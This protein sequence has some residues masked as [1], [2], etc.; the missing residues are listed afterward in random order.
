MEAG[1]KIIPLSEAQEPFFLGI[2]VGGMSTKIGLV[3]NFGKVIHLGSCE[4]KESG[5]ISVKTEMSPQSATQAMSKAVY[6]ML[7]K[8]GVDISRV[9]AIGLGIPGTMELTTRRLRR[10]PNIGP[11]EGFPMCDALKESSGISVFFCN[12]A[13]AAAFGEYWVGSASGMNS[14][15]LL[16]LGTGIGTGIIIDGKSVEGSIGYGGECGHL[17]ID[18]SPNARL[19]GCGQIGHLE[20]YAGAIG[21]ARRTLEMTSTK[22]SLLNEMITPDVSLSQIP[23]LVYDAASKGDTLAMDIIDETARYLSLGIVSILNTIDPACILLG[24]AMTFGGSEDPVGRTFI[25]MIRE[26]VSRYAFPAIAKS[27]K[28]DYAVLGS[29]AGYI[30]AAG[31]AR[32][33]LCRS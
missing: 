6:E 28:I 12:D 9:F 7:S 23:K 22:R 10:P 18:T 2:D 20:A 27:V 17:V 8:G 3:D 13:N 29:D 16:T 4:A 31:I 19:C 30:G 1:R 15:A 25:G 32:D 5:F 24:G 33:M 11:W 26:K 14:V 21:V